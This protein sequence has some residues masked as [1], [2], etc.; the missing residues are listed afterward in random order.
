[1]DHEA[2]ASTIVGRLIESRMTRRGLSRYFLALGAT[3]LAGGLLA[4]CGGDDDDDDDADAETPADEPAPTAT[5]AAEPEATEPPAGEEDDGE[6]TE[7]E[8]EPTAAD[9]DGDDDEPAETEEPGEPSAAGQGVPLPYDIEEPGQQGGQIV[10][11]ETSEPDSA[12][13]MIATA[14]SRAGVF[15]NVF[16]GLI[17]EDPTDGSPMPCLASAWEISDDGLVYTFTLQEGV[18]WHDGAPFTANDVKFTIDL[19]FDEASASPRYGSWTGAV[20]SYEAVD[21]HQLTITLLKPNA[22]FLVTQGLQGIVPE[23]ALGD[24][25]PEELAQ[26]PFSTGE[27][28]VTIGTGPFMLE[29]WVSNDYILFRAYE[30]YWQGRPYLDT[31]VH[32]IV[33]SQAVLAQQLRTGEID[34]AYLQ[35]SD[36]EGMQ[37]EPSLNIVTFDSARTVWYGYQLDPERTTLFQDKAVRQALFYALDREPMVEV[38]E[39]GLGQVATGMMTPISW[40]YDPDAI[41]LHYEHD[42]DLANQL[43]D[44][45]GWELGDDGVRVKDGQ[46]LSFTMHTFSG[47]DQMEQYIV[48]MQQQWAEIGVEL[49]PQFEESNAFTS[50]LLSSHDFESFLFNNSMGTD[51]DQSIYW[52]CDAYENG[53]NMTRYCNPEVDELAEAGL[54]ATTLEARKEIYDEL[55]NIMLDDLPVAF[56]VYQQR[57][58]A[59]NKRVHNYY[60]NAIRTWPGQHKWWVDA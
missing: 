31:F 25:A 8:P 35:A 19:I 16:E 47:N 29:E 11:G 41:E 55:Q 34:I 45:A 1:M 22:P 40:A 4:A 30:N 9:D 54:A 33:P 17:Q 43:L 2:Q 3:S 44:D 36:L 49:I 56:L 32:R 38:L 58:M 53:L 37:D 51:P 15:N 10:V 57:V 24:V 59:V 60:P 7:E 20:E 18:T 28:G 26:H 23:H 39:F 21:D 12:N 13:P 6:A 5:E 27:A 50:R 42:Q 46:R 14:S 48:V 52:T